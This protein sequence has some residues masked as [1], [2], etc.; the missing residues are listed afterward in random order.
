LRDE[1]GGREKKTQ[2]KC[3]D[4]NEEVSH[5]PNRVKRIGTWVFLGTLIAERARATQRRK[6]DTSGSGLLGSRSQSLC[7]PH[8]SPGLWRRS[9]IT[10][11]I[12]IWIDRTGLKRGEKKRKEKKDA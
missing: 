10:A 12:P 6:K 4:G 9:N 8:N 7:R 3:S 11:R 2:V 1:S 5:S